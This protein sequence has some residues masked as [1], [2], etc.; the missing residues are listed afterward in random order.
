MKRT[1]LMRRYV[2]NQ[3]SP[4]TVRRYTCSASRCDAISSCFLSLFLMSNALILP[5]L[6]LAPVMLSA[7]EL[8]AIAPKLFSQAPVIDGKLD[9]ADWRDTLEA[10]PL[11]D[12]A[13][14]NRIVKQRTVFKVGYDAVNLYLGVICQNYSGSTNR[15]E[16][17]AADDDG[18]FNDDS[19]EIFV[20]PERLGTNYYQFVI[21]RRGTVWDA[22]NQWTAGALKINRQWNGNA[23][24]AVD[25]LSNQWTAELAI[26][27][28]ALEVKPENGKK[29]GL[30]VNRN[31][32][33]CERSNGDW[34][35]KYVMWS[36]SAKGFQDT[37]AF[38]NLWFGGEAEILAAIRKQV[39]ELKTEALPAERKI[40]EALQKN[41]PRKKEFEKRYANLFAPVLKSEGN[42]SP[43]VRAGDLKIALTIIRNE[44]EDLYYDILFARL[45]GE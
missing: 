30:G 8:P 43:Y 9:E 35:T 21:N 36:P 15:M 42:V 1:M 28:S 10:G 6:V 40:R 20:N 39:E 22:A 4:H 17:L 7:G 29:W 32:T 25:C 3:N 24:A 18:I 13:D 44:W 11:F 34:L 19:L 33:R 12:S 45:L 23:Q 14:V 27:F 2:R 26:P 41:P 38:G 16:T 37:S 5:V 31:L